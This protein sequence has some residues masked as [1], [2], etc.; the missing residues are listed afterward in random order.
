MG[1]L[2]AGVRLGGVE[3]VVCGINGFS[4]GLEFAKE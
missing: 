4:D 1:A 2:A 3:A